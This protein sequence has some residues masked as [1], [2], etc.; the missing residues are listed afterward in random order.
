MTESGPSILVVDSDWDEGRLI[1]GV[2]REAGFEVETAADD[3]G[4]AAAM[5]DKCFAAAV[6]ALPEGDGGALLRRARRRQPGLKALMIVEPA[7]MRLVHEDCATLVK[8]PFDPRELLGCVFA[9]VLREDEQ[10]PA[11][12]HGHAVAEFGIAAAKLVC[13]H[14]R[15]VAAA[16]TGA[17]RLAQ[18]L[19]HQIGEMTAAHRGLGAASFGRLAIVR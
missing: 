13:L 17:H 11:P 12:A 18:E 15:R 7:A 8:R 19:T 3:A 6:I 10:E 4:A 2:L 1:A 14:N 5:R 16:A 9:L